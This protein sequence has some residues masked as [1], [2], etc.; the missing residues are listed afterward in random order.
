MVATSP[1]MTSLRKTDESQRMMHAPKTNLE[2]AAI[3]GGVRA[4]LRHD[5][6]HKHVSGEAVYVDDMPEPPGTLQIYIAMSERAHAGVKVLDVA[7]VR[8]APGV[9]LVLTAKDVPGA[10][11]VS[12]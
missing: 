10:N 7:K 1:T 6:G 3:E 2:K 8:R 9:A 4:A 5:S 12:P 11:D